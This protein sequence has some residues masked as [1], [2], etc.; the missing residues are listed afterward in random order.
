MNGYALFIEKECNFIHHIEMGQ[1]E[2]K[3][4]MDQLIPLGVFSTR[5]ATE[6]LSISQPTFS[7][8]VAQSDLIQKVSR[9]YY[10]HT[11]ADINYEYLD[12]I[13]ACKKFG[14]NAVIGGLSALARISHKLPTAVY[15]F[16]PIEP[17][18]P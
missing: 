4:Q 14:K 2:L 8:W 15:S 3:S 12:Y 1:S 13:V 5:E 6:R 18:T 10:V 11:Q 9:G 17:P 7:R 16:A